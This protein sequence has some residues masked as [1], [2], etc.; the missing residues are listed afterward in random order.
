MKSAASSGTA[1][2]EPRWISPLRYPGGK[3]SLVELLGKTIQANGVF[4]RPYYE[5][6][7]G[8]GGAALGLLQKGAVSA[9]HLNDYDPCVYAFWKAILEQ[10]ARFEKAIG[11]VPLTIEEWQRQKSVYKDA[12]HRKRKSFALGFATFF[13]NRCSRSGII[14]GSAPIGGYRQDGRWKID[15]RFNR[16]G[17]IERVWWLTK[18]RDR[19]SISNDDALDFL[20]NGVPQGNDRKMVFVYLDPPYYTHGRRLYFNSYRDDDHRKLAR[21]MKRQRTLKWIMS[22]DDSDFIRALYGDMIRSHKG[23]QYSLQKRNWTREL[24]I[25][26]VY[27][28]L[29]N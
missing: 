18:H 21:Y 25:A 5:P 9:V 20:R 14:F 12:S 15:A 7:V 13:L 29:P 4:Q 2:A 10:S 17:L 24:L 19:I 3:A 26:P 27:V 6:F 11:E 1:S 28:D 16:I 22:Y 23:M 8:G